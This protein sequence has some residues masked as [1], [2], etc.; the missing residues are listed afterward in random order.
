MIEDWPSQIAVAVRVRQELGARDEL[1]TY[2][3]PRPA[4][5]TE[6]IDRVEGAIG[7]LD[8]GYRAF[9]GH[10]DGWPAFLQE[11]DLFGTAEL[12]GGPAAA[13]DEL[14]DVLDDDVWE[15]LGVRRDELHVIGASPTGD[16]WLIARPGTRRAGEVRWFWGSDWETFPDFDEFFLAMVNYNRLEL[17]RLE[18]KA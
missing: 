15:A 3:P 10:A 4:A 16:L 11:T 8:P 12:A 18:G 17:R 6:A 1:M 13:A 2:P 7:P 14:L 9:L 5:G